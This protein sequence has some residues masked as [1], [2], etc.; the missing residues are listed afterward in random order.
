LVA[1]Q[2]ATLEAPESH[3][4]ERVTV[5]DGERRVTEIVRCTDLFD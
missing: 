2:F 1:S 5:L 3:E 4:A